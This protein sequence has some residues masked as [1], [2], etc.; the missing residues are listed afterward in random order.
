M[1][2]IILIYGLLSGLIASVWM[3]FIGSL[4][5]D[6][7]MSIGMVIGFAAMIL[8]FSFIFV[9]IIKY[10]NNVNQGVISFGQSFFI[11]AMIS[12]IASTMYVLGWEIDF[13]YFIPDFFDKYTEAYMKGLKDSGIS[14]AEYNKAY[15]KMLADGEAY[16]NNRWYR[17]GLTYLEILPLGIIISL[18]AA[19]ILKRN[20]PK[21]NLE[22]VS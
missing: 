14:E 6:Q 20:K 10:R 22:P 5:V 7:M 8:G 21:T 13:N 1:Q 17:M 18:I 12:I 15:Q 19:L 4:G 9:A 2:R 3:V 11:G 16:K